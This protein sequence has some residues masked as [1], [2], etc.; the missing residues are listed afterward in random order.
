MFHPKEYLTRLLNVH[1]N[2]I[3]KHEWGYWPKYE[4]LTNSYWNGW[5][6]K[7]IYQ[8]AW[9]E[10][11]HR[12]ALALKLLI[13]EPTGALSRVPLFSSMQIST[14]SL[15]RCCRCQPYIQS[16]WIHRRHQELVG[17]S[18]AIDDHWPTTLFRDYRFVSAENAVHFWAHHAFSQGLLD[19]RLLVYIVRPHTAGLHIRSKWQVLWLGRFRGIFNKPI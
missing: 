7:S 2:K 4:Q 1:G 12:S 11:V 3:Y 15:R 17:S 10:A 19:S 6:R 13:Y 16:T 5:V 14:C 9:K 18:L 8:G